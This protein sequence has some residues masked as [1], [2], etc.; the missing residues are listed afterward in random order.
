M[1]NGQRRISTILH[2]E[3]VQQLPVVIEYVSFRWG[4]GNVWA[5]CG[6]LGGDSGAS[7]RATV[8]DIDSK[9]LGGSDE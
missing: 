9:R 6:E 8:P 4:P 7:T 3:S 1:A 5:T 2:L